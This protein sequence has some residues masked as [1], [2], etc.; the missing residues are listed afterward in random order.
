MTTTVI[1]G[2][3]ILGGEPADILIRDGV[4]AEIGPETRNRG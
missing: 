4:V 3:K 2:A 1:K